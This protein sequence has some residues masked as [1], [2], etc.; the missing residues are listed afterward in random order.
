MGVFK[1]YHVLSLQSKFF[2]SCLNNIALMKLCLDSIGSVWT[3]CLWRQKPGSAPSVGGKRVSLQPT[4]MTADLC[5]GRIHTQVYA[6]VPRSLISPPCPCKVYVVRAVFSCFILQNEVAWRQNIRSILYTSFHLQMWLSTNRAVAT[7]L[8]TTTR[9]TW[10][11]TF[12]LTETDDLEAITVCITY[13]FYVLA[14]DPCGY[15]V[16]E[17]KMYFKHFTWCFPSKFN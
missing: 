14:I 16:Q 1:Q 9:T 6:V 5:S 11:H 4:Q 15:V 7:A 3:L 12:E 2:D 10:M 17:C 13:P 8:N